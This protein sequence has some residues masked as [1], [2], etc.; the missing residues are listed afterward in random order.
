MNKKSCYHY[1]TVNGLRG[2]I[3][4]SKL[5][6]TAIEF[7]NDPSE[8]IYTDKLIEEVCSQNNKLKSIY[9]LLYSS[10]YESLLNSGTKRFIISMSKK[11]DSLPMWNYYSKGNGYCIRFKNIDELLDI[12]DRF[13]SYRNV[14][15]DYNLHKQKTEIANTIENY[16]TITGDI[17]NEIADAG[18]STIK[19]RRL[20]SLSNLEV[21]VKKLG[22]A[23]SVEQQTFM[24]EIFQNRDAYKHPAYREEKEIRV[25]LELINGI[26]YEVDSATEQYPLKYRTTN[27]GQ[28]VEYIEVPIHKEIIDAVIIHPLIS[29]DVHELGLQK[30]LKSKGMEKVEII[31]S[32]VPFRNV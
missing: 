1:T 15:I 9:K 13:I 2:I 11:S 25:I 14:E 29:D 30:Y 23:N 5:W 31:R 3:E 8:N 12:S 18:L 4:S 17:Y 22:I 32:S 26:S 20:N 16:N 21:L 24:N 10:N 6:A 28:I 27:T 7:L 19:S